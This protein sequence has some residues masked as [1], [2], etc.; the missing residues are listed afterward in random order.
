MVRDTRT[1]IVPF[2]NRRSPQFNLVFYLTIQ[3]SRA[4]GKF[5]QTTAANWVRATSR[6]KSTCAMPPATRACYRE[7]SATE[8]RA[9]RAYHL[10]RNFRSQMLKR[11]F[12]GGSDA[13]EAG[14]RL[15]V[16]EEL[17]H[18][19]RKRI[20]ILHNT[21]L[22]QRRCALLLT[23]F[24]LYPPTP[25]VSSGGRQRGLHTPA[26]V[27]SELASRLKPKSDT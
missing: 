23:I 20:N 16:R 7:C 27:I 9:A 24:V 1:T 4:I 19:Q 11:R 8:S 21:I 26:I 17:P 12:S 18:N 13:V 10:H 14:K 22:S 6:A 25:R 3:F 2:G 15:F 5:D